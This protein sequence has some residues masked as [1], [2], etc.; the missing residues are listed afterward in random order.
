MDEVG[1]AVDGIHHP[2]RGLCQL[3]G[4][5][6]HMQ[7]TENLKMNMMEPDRGVPLNEKRS[8]GI[9]PPPVRFH[10]SGWEATCG[11]VKISSLSAKSATCNAKGQT[12]VSHPRLLFVRCLL[13][14]HPE[15]GSTGPTRV[16]AGGGGARRC[17]V[18]MLPSAAKSHKLGT[19]PLQPF[20]SFHRRH[21]NCSHKPGKQLQPPYPLRAA[22]SAQQSPKSSWQRAK[23]TKEYEQNLLGSRIL[24]I[25]CVGGK[26]E[27]HSKKSNLEDVTMDP[28]GL[29]LLR[30]SSSACRSYFVTRSTDVPFS[31]NTCREGREPRNCLAVEHASGL[32]GTLHCLG[33][34]RFPLLS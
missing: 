10:V 13:R 21:K 3:L 22:A 14:H 31:S 15:V 29:N 12:I 27:Q 4:L 2:G 26:P 1:G 18:V 8:S 9:P 32:R 28:S 6:S 34:C 17:L 30:T 5:A 24:Q 11:C 23:K 20:H 25:T 19:L 16:W 7:K 33:V